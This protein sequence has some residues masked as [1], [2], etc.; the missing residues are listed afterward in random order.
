M[1]AHSLVGRAVSAALFLPFG[2]VVSQ[3]QPVLA[4]VL[5]IRGVYLL[6]GT[7]G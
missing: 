5:R 6:A 3:V 7:G 1:S 4:W 2:H